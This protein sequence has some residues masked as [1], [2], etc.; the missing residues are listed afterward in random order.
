[1]EIGCGSGMTC[2]RR[3]RDWQEEGV[4]SRQHK[5]LLERLQAA[6][7]IDWARVG[8]MHSTATTLTDR[9]KAGIKRHFVTDARGMPLGLTLSGANCHDIRML[10]AT[11]DA[12]P[13]VR[14][15]TRTPPPQARQTARRQGL[16]SSPLPSGVPHPGRHSS[17]WPPRHREQPK[18]RQAPVVHRAYFRLAQSLSAPHHPPRTSRRHPLGLRHTCLRLCLPQPDPQVFL[19]AL[20]IVEL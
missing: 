20:V 1:M 15:R 12:V 9:G 7:A 14:P 4:W 6:V 10:A 5:M 11:L 3:L 18:A 2:W 13:R 19:D 16:R 17:D 8:C